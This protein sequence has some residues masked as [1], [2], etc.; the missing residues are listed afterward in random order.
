MVRTLA[1]GADTVNAA[2]AFMFSLGCIQALQCGNNTCPTGIATQD[3]RLM[4]GL[5]VPSKTLRVSQFQKATVHAAVELCEAAG[6]K[7]PA[8]LNVNHIMR[9]VS[10][11][12]IRTLAELYPT[13]EPGSLLTSG[14]LVIAGGANRAQSE[15]A[16]RFVHNM[17][18]MWKLGKI[19]LDQFDGK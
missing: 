19:Q 1:L 11:T 13:A 9:R 15:D 16:D 17:N 5:H 3:Q 18:H 8:D 12:Q 10:S 14:G 4:G 6:L 7:S 2:R